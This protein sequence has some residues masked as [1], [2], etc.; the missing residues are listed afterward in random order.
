M[1]KVHVVE[2]GV[3]ALD[4]ISSLETEGFGREDVYIFAHGENRSEDLSEA[5]G[6]AEIGTKEQGMF[7]AVGNLFKSRG[8]ELRSK[9]ESLGL[10][11]QEAQ[12]YEKELDQGRVVVVG[13]K[14]E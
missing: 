8:D 6:T 7:E 9:M 11:Q 13:S 14:G 1:Y 4:T 2:N 12:D 10:S 3:Q 5:T